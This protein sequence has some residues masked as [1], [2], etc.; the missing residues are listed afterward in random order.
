MNERTGKEVELDDIVK[1]YDTGGE[2][3]LQK[4]LDEIAAGRSHFLKIAG[5]VDL[6]QVE[7][8]FFDRSTRVP[9]RTKGKDGLLTFH[10]A[11]LMRSG[12]VLL[13]ASVT[14]LVWD[15]RP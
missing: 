6:G 14:L 11:G 13:V 10:F 7:S 1:G 5:F 9:W 12:T 15:S 4:E 2:Y 8:V 3:V